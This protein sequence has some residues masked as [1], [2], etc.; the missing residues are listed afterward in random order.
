MLFLLTE[1]EAIDLLR[2]AVRRP[3]GLLAIDVPEARLQEAGEPRP[4]L[5]FD[6]T[7]RT[8]HCGKLSARLSPTQFELLQYVYDNER[9]SY[10]ELQDAIW[11]QNATDDAIRRVISKLNTKLMDCGFPL[12][13]LS[14]HSRVSIAKV[15]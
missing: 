15:G 6:A 14:H 3:D 11:Q 4:V 13:I 1:S 5:T 8:V 7:A 12:E 2:E 9:A 10:E